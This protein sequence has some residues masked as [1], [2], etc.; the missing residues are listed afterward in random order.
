MV[1]PGVSSQGPVSCKSSVDEMLIFFLFSFHT[2][3]INIFFYF[4][5]KTCRGYSLESARRVKSNHYPHDIFSWGHKK[6]ILSGYLF[7]ELWRY[8]EKKTLFCVI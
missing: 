7:L 4:S 1:S 6:N 8:K 2:N 3:I 5:S